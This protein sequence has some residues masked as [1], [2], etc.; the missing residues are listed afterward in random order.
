MFCYND[1]DARCESLILCYL[2]NP[3]NSCDFGRSRKGGGYRNV[4]GADTEA[5][6]KLRGGTISASFV[7][8]AIER[9][10]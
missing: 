4:A 9:I 1:L 2:G 7:R 10:G 5:K 6:L 3:P 8:L